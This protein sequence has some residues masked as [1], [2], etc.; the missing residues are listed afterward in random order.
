MHGQGIWCGQTQ[1]YLNVRLLYVL[2][3]HM[4]VLTTSCMDQGSVGVFSV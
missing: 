3:R 2:T 4:Q 1:S